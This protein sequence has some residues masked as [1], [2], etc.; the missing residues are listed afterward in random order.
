MI[1]T[2]SGSRAVEELAI[3]DPVLTADGRS[4]P[5]KWLGRQSFETIFGMPEPRRPVLISAGAL[6]NDLPRR[7]LRVTSDHALM[8]DGLLVQAGALVN[9]TTIRRLMREEMGERMTVFHVETEGHE[10]I[11]AEGSEVESFVDNVS[12]ERFDNYAEY[13]ELYGEPGQS[14]QELDAPR[15]KSWR[16][17]PA[18]IRARLAVPAAA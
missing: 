7:D 16:Q 10:I 1:A 15:V 14:M 9:G 5:V 3:G 11:L 12:R 8:I 17:L 2:P 4:V 6:G 13:V 18:P